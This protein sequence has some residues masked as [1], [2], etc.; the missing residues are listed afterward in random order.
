MAM[1]L[2][3]SNNGTFVSSDGYKLQD[4]DGLSLSALPANGK[5]KIILNGVVYRFNIKLP[6]KESE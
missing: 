4:N 3:V 5:L 6:E 1:Y 2:G